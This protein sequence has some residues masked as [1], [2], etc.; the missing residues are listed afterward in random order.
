MRIARASSSVRAPGVDC[1]CTPEVKGKQRGSL[2]LHS[3]VGGSCSNANCLSLSSLLG[4]SVGRLCLTA[5][6]FVGLASHSWGADLLVRGGRLIDGVRSA[7]IFADI[8]IRDG[9]IHEIGPHL[10][11]DAA[12]VIDASGATVLPGLIDSHVHLEIVPGS[13]FRQDSPDALA[14]LRQ[15]HLRAYLACGVTTVLDAGISRKQGAAI[16][17]WLAAGNHGPRFL[18]LGQPLATPSGYHWG[19]S[20]TVAQIS[21]LDHFFELVESSEAVGIKVLI[22][23]GWSPFSAL[24]IPG[25][26][27]LEAIKRRA[28]ARGLPIFV[29]SRTEESHNLALDLGAHALTHLGFEEFM[30]SPTLIRR[31]AL[32]GTYVIT[33]LSANEIHMLQFAPERLGKDYLAGVVPPR[34]LDSAMD[35]GALDHVR[36]GVIGLGVPWLPESVAVWVWHALVDQD[37]IASRTRNQQEALL[38][39]SQAGA[40]IVVGSD[41]PGFSFVPYMFHGPTTI[42]EIELLGEAGMSPMQAIVAATQTPAEMLLLDDELGT[43]AVG[44]RA[45]IL[46]VEGDPLVDLSSLRNVLW[47]IHDGHARTPIGWMT[48]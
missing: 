35:P 2:R 27:L 42:R 18:T 23:P 28:Q 17:E 30:P 46:I 41:S 15:Q 21:E 45:D 38:K 3:T 24:P 37:V 8:L 48:E 25:K 36:A 6:A 11:S 9:W 14:G 40:K 39:F 32:S 34:E 1:W 16:R 22:E 12:Q 4:K 31:A 10:S 29:H 43:I 47:T 13:S 33:T 5:L 19:A 20:Q 7:P 26:A 44:K